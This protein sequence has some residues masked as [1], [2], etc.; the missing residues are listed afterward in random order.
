MLKV[1]IGLLFEAVLSCIVNKFYTSLKYNTFVINVAGKPKSIIIN[2]DL[3]EEKRTVSGVIISGYL[4]VVLKILSL[5]L[6][7][8]KC[9]NKVRTR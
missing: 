4:M 1:F 6:V 7:P 2:C 8:N 3:R 9:N 5:I